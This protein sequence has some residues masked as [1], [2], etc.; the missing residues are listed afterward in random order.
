MGYILKGYIK[1]GYK[2]KKET[3]R[4]QKKREMKKKP[5]NAYPKFAFR[6]DT[7]TKDEILTW[8]DSLYFQYQ[9][10]K[11]KDDRTVKKNDIIID[12]IRIGLQK[13]EQDM[14]KIPL[15]NKKEHSL[16]EWQKRNPKPNGK[17]NT[18]F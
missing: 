13:I 14:K 5:S 15:V 7:E 4:I 16:K 10:R 11:K 6:V 8:V 12:A 18:L 3:G 9:D 1:L 2:I 17:G